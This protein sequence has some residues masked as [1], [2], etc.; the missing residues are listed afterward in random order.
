LF[1]AGIVVV[2]VDLQVGHQHPV[3]QLHEHSASYYELVVVVDVVVAERLVC[4]EEGV[5]RPLPAYPSQISE[6]SL[7]GLPVENVHHSQDWTPVFGGIQ[8]DS[9]GRVLASP[10]SVLHQHYFRRDLRHLF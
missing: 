5:H 8:T 10:A 1:S 2:I 7:V 3:E 4:L 9:A 6:I